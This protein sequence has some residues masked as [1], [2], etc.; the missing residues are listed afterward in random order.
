[1]P[2]SLNTHLENLSSC[3]L[4]G[5]PQ[6]ILSLISLIVMIPSG[7]SR[8]LHK[9]FWGQAKVGVNPLEVTESMRG[10]LRGPPRMLGAG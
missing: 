5:P 6:L 7:L 9:I 3:V 8:N 2:G 1:M 4:L 10:S